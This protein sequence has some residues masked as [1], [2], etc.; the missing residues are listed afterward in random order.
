MTEAHS[1]KTK[2]KYNI[3]KRKYNIR[4]RYLQTKQN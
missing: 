3:R 4:V 1:G 2:R